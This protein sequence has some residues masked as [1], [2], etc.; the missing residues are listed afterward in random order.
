M[1]MRKSSGLAFA[2]STIGLLS[3]ALIQVRSNDQDIPVPQVTASSNCKV[4]ESENIA[5]FNALDWAGEEVWILLAA[6]E[7]ESVPND[8]RLQFDHS[9][10]FP[11]AVSLHILEN[12][13]DWLLGSMRG[14]EFKFYDEIHP[15][16]SS[17]IYFPQ[18]P[19]F[20]ILARASPPEPFAIASGQEIALSIFG[21]VNFSV[22]K[23]PQQISGEI[24]LTAK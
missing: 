10:E 6:V 12:H 7:C 11:F 23:L 20:Q 5:A 8:I 2:I 21:T 18:H 1:E 14:S 16:T 4:K 9:S 17:G 3:L 24:V 15:V 19:Q 22:D 13:N